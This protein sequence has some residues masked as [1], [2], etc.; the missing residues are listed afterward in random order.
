MIRYALVCDKAHEFDSWFP[1]SDAFDE[2]AR[3]GFVVCPVCGSAKV[4]KA[5][6]APAIATRRGMAEVEAVTASEPVPLLDERE[7]KMRTLARQ[8][9]EHVL[10]NTEDVGP[11]FPEEARAMHEGTIE[12]RP[13]MGE[14]SMAEVRELLEDGVQVMPVPGAVDGR[15]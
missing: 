8:M 15:H 9:R 11:R 4:G 13:I 3:R 2:Q 10:A 14:A 6:M 12:P 5:M 1:G 7:A